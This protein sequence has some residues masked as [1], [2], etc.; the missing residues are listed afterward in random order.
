MKQKN[1]D[2]L[3]GLSLDILDNRY[4]IE[5]LIGELKN[6]LEVGATHCDLDIE[7][8]DDYIDHAYFSFYV[9]RDE[10]DE[11]LQYREEVEA[12]MEKRREEHQ[13]QQ[14]KYDYQQYLALKKKYE[15]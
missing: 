4:T 6:R 2:Y 13:K 5:E 15:G 12:E 3:K 7:C 10:T 1:F 9:E 8:Y 14:E 11:E